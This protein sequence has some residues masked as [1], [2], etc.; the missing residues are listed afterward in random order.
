MPYAD[1][2]SIINLIKNQENDGV[3]ARL[4]AFS[5][6]SFTAGTAA[7][8]TSGYISANR[9]PITFTVPSV[10]AS[11]NGWLFDAS[12]ISIEDNALLVMALEYDLGVLTVS[13]NSFAAGSDA[14][15]PTKTTRIAGTT[16]TNDQTASMLTMA[17]ATTAL[18]GATTPTLTITYV[19]EDGTASRTATLTL[20][21][22]PVI[23]TAFDITPHLQSGDLG[24]Q[25][26]TNISISA[27]TAGIIRI[28]GLLPLVW[29]T[30]VGAGIGGYPSLSHLHK[31]FPPII[32]VANEIIAFY[33]FGVATT[34]DLTACL[35]GKP[36]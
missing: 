29:A 15:M 22:N 6:A 9:H 8:I 1:L 2:D 3:L 16:Y 26:I 14:S 34:S 17:V 12:V 10:S 21:T 23:N 19:N 36:I 11:Y 31:P 18:A 35:H 27:G 32:A 25:D 33:R 13:G 7:N 4:I 20:P 24:V 5:N 30:A 28:K